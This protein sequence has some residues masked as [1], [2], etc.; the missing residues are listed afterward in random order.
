MPD[1]RKN[2]KPVKINQKSEPRGSASGNVASA[3]LPNLSH[4]KKLDIFTFF[5]LFAFGLY[6][7][8]IY[9]G[10]QPV[11]HFD[12][13]CFVAIG[14]EILNFQL[15]TDYKRVPLT[16][17][18]QIFLGHIV[19]G[20]SP[21]LRGGWLLNSLSHT[22]TIVF[23]WLAGRKLIGKNAIWFA[24]IAI[25]N[26][27]GLQLLTESIAETPM[28]FF[29]WITI[30]LI[31]IRS[32][33]AWLFACLATMIRYEC[34]ALIAGAF[35]IEMIEGNKKQRIMACVY[36]ALAS[37]P[38]GVWMFGTFMQSDM[39]VTHYLNI[40]KKDYTSQ[41]AEG[42][43]NR[44]G[45]KLN[46]EILWQTGFYPLLQPS[47]NAGESFSA[48]L[49]VISRIF[50]SITFLFGSLYGLFKKQWKILVLLI[51][52]IPYFIIH[53]KYPYPIHRYYATIFGMVMLIC[54]YGIISFWSLVKNRIPKP[55][56]ILLQACLLLTCLVWAMILWGFLPQLSQM[57]TAS[58][59]LP[60]IAILVSAIAFGIL[61]YMNKKTI[62][63]SA[64]VFSL[65]ILMIVSNQF[66]I[67]QIVGNGDRDIE[68][69]YLTDWY[70]QNAKPT[71][72]LVTT[73]PT[74]L[75]IL[76]PQYKDNFIHTNTFDANSPEDFV[77]ECY[78]KNITYVAWDSREGLVPS[79][80]YYKYWKMSNIAPLAAA[81][82][83]GPYQFIT[84]IR[85]NQRRYINLYRL[86]PLS[87][88]Q[89]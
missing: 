38:L 29:T 56:T 42:V 16:G 9:W 48:T 24:I 17:I 69:K 63:T 2:P 86:R 53:V 35:L 80:H 30:Y 36:A 76:A 15:P 32:R 41:F 57:S 27:F 43:Q 74:I 83:I 73:V 10:H 51:F 31:F 62:F 4:D 70:L 87:Q 77:R 85:V 33:W 23:I 18:L 88:I 60:Y 89:N 25:I 78:K 65:M 19:G 47:P 40:F 72:K 8:I 39:G 84:Q 11:P 59:S 37:I 66:M 21:E 61:A 28:L 67:A 45:F 50:V 82:D 79:D 5:L 7:S 55:V 58:V 22:L 6:Q 46:A 1:K 71:E 20:A 81:K 12:F 26:P 54:V 75:T 64:V 52:L 14:R 34:A 49:M 3:S 68:F 13:Q 44:T